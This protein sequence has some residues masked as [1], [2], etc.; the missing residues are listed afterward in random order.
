[1]QNNLKKESFVIEMDL[2]MIEAVAESRITSK[3]LAITNNTSH[4]LHDMLSLLE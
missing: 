1:M 3:L 2:D 4:P